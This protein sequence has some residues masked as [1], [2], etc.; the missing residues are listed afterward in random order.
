MKK[1]IILAFFGF[2]G[3]YVEAPSKRRK[4]DYRPSVSTG[5]LNRVVVA[6]A[7]MP[8]SVGN[9]VIQPAQAAGAQSA[10]GLV[11][12]IVPHDTTHQVVVI[13]APSVRPP[14]PLGP[15]GSPGTIFLN[16]GKVNFRP[17]DDVRVECFS[18]LGGDWKPY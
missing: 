8:I 3:V 4:N 2:Y 15:L 5:I 12:V 7:P 18:Q 1:T 14:L 10:Q 13:G 11:A 6:S 16:V 17:G 9:Q